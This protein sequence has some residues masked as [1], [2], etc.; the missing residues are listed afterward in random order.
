[1]QIEQD[2]WYHPGQEMYPDGPRKNGSRMY[3]QGESIFYER[4]NYDEED[5]REYEYRGQ[6][7]VEDYRKAMQELQEKGRAEIGG[8][9]PRDSEATQ[10]QGLSVS[11]IFRRMPDWDGYVELIFSGSSL[12]C[13]PGGAGVSGSLHGHHKLEQLLLKE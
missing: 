12:S 2:F 4:N 7:T 8:L 10:R 3:R 6:F 9:D 13:S 5:S 1:M 11:L